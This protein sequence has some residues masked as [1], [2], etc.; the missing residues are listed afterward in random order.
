ML[1]SLFIFVIFAFSLSLLLY[2]MNKNGYKD[3]YTLFMFSFILI[4]WVIPMIIYSDKTEISLIDFRSS[5]WLAIGLIYFTI[6]AVT[7]YCLG[8]LSK[9]LR[10]KKKVF[11]YLFF[12]YSFFLF[13]A[14]FVK[15]I[16]IIYWLAIGSS[17]LSGTYGLSVNYWMEN[18]TKRKCY[19]TNFIFYS[20]PFLGV[21]LSSSFT[22]IFNMQQS[23]YIWS[24]FFALLCCILIVLGFILYF[25]PEK[26]IVHE[27][28]TTISNEVIFKN[29][30]WG[31]F[32]VYL[33]NGLLL[34]MIYIPTN[35]LYLFYFS[36]T[37]TTKNLLIIVT[38]IAFISF[39]TVILFTQYLTKHL[40]YFHLMVIGISF[41]II[42]MI[43]GAITI[44][45]YPYQWEWIFI[46]LVIITIGYISLHSM[47]YGD[48]VH[49]S[50]KTKP[51]FLTHFL[52]INS[53]SLLISYTFAAQIYILDLNVITMIIIISSMSLIC[54]SIYLYLFMKNIFLLNNLR[55]KFTNYEYFDIE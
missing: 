16:S 20:L 42:G 48:A 4:T 33:L 9:F 23:W 24:I 22:K 41:L 6:Q 26:K 46:S 40:G 43:L 52:T 28:D 7:R 18:T 8:W 36:D 38:S 25:F 47:L 13:V 51:I 30:E 19:Q 2:F 1:F 37:V 29:F 11:A 17:I 27:E 21:I 31:K 5:S 49:I 45:I 54:L 50:S 10:S 55:E 12:L 44:L 34:P 35:V 3:L 53:F 32:K 39:M 14:I 15:N